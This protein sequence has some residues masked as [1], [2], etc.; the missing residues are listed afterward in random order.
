[1]I[2]EKNADLI[3]KYDQLIYQFDLKFE[4]KEEKTVCETLRML[5]LT[6]TYFL[7]SHIYND[8]AAIM[9]NNGAL[10][11]DAVTDKLVSGVSSA[12]DK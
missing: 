4:K 12:A 10:D 1:M 3:T 8:K 5:I 11:Y 9:M 6:K 7:C 2:T